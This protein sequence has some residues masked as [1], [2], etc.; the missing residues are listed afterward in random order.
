MSDNNSSTGSLA[1]PNAG[2][3]GATPPTAATPNAGATNAAGGSTGSPTGQQPQQSNQQPEPFA[4]FENA[5]AF[6]KRMAREAR[7][8][9]D[10]NARDLGFDGWEQMQNV[11]GQRQ[12]STP[13]D[14]GTQPGAVQATQGA[15]EAQRLRMA[16]QVGA[17]L[18]VPPALISRLQGDTLEE[19]QQDARNLMLLMPAGPAPARAGPG[20]PPVQSG[21]QGQVGFT[22]QQLSNPDFVRKNTAQILEAARAGLPTTRR[23]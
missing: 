22:E 9:M 18:N 2:A 14:A 13:A 3:E 5:D 20:I 11:F 6:N 10:K 8:L 4:V 1:T 15:N 19:M 12:P 16:I 23:S 21:N 17:E 7:K